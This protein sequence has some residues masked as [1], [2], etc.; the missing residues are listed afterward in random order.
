MSA[1]APSHI[2]IYAEEAVLGAAMLLGD[3]RIAGALLARGLRAEHFSQPKHAV[4]Y[5]AI[6]SL[7]DRQSGIDFA[8]VW[9]ELDRQGHSETLQ[10]SEVEYITS[11]VPASGNHGD[12]ADRVIEL[13]RWRSREKALEDMARAAARRDGAAW[14]RAAGALE[15]ST[16]GTRTDSLSGEQM[17]SVMFDYFA[18]PPEKVAE[19]AIPFPFGQINDALGGGLRPGEVCLLAGPSEHGKSLLGD[20]WADH[21]SAHGKR[22]H[23]YLTEMTFLMRGMRYLARQTGVPFI[24]QR[25]PTRLTDEDRHKITEELGRGPFPYGFSVVS[26]WAIDDVVRDALRARYD[27]VIVDLLHGFHYED[28]RGL[29]RL[30]KAMQRLARTSTL[31][32]G[33][34]G[35]A[36]IAV[37]H[38]KEEGTVKGRVPRPTIASLK[39]GSSLKQ[40]ADAV[41]FVWQE[42]DDAANPTGD[43]EIWLAKGRSMGKTRIK[44]RLNP[45]RFR[46]ELRPD[47]ASVA[48]IQEGIPF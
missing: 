10:R 7:A 15:T 25:L 36:V 44:V 22:G 5:S 35:T 37:T 1:S 14:G 24:R 43:G 4:I 31:L 29:D 2:D 26:D 46:F 40:D 6:T 32:D 23:V 47:E 39:G 16:V 42:Q 18:T 38:L 21:A 45:A 27:W 13:A 48:E 41:C 33:H 17:R 20:M 8:T 19:F 9:A 30:S 11:S 3:A 12:Y 34:R 28:E